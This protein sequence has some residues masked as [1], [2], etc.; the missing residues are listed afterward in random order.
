[1]THTPSPSSSPPPPFPPPGGVQESQEAAQKKQ[2]ERRALLREH[3]K[4]ERQL[5]TQGRIKK[6]F[7][8]KKCEQNT[9][10]LAATKVH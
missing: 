5:Y 10:L 8:L 2:E 4:A 3:K 6:P 9:L 1:M 7:F